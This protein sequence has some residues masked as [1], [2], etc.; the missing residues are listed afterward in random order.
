MRVGKKPG[1]RERLLTGI[2]RG[3]SK[4]SRYGYA[5]GRVMVNEAS[6][7]T[8]NQV[9]RL[10]ESD[11]DDALT[12]SVETVY[13]P[14]LEGSSVPQDIQSGLAGF[15]ADQYRFLDEICAGTH[16]AEF[17][18]LKYDFHNMKVI[19][20]W[21]Y[22][23][24]LKDGKPVIELGA[25][26]TEAL[27]EAVE[28]RQ[29]NRLPGY[30]KDVIGS[31]TS[32]LEREEADPQLL[33][34]IL[35]RAFLERR[36]A[37]AEKEGS[38]LMVDFCRAAVD[39]AN[40]NVTLRGKRLGKEREFYGEALAEG[41]RLLK[42]DLL[43]LSDEPFSV[44]A[45]RL[46]GSRYGSMLSAVLE[47]GDETVRLTTLDRASDEYILDKVR[48]FSRVSVGPERIVR[49]MLARE[50]EVLMLKI[51]FMGK[52]HSLTPEVIEARLPLS[53]IKQPAW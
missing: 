28:E 50:N 4:A 2:P 5:V 12:V 43:E 53:Y 8:W 42:K 7:V 45:D 21:H 26:A 6:F 35:D 9:Q 47:R 52:L 10:I 48:G 41:G 40:L 49:Y 51:I 34:T 44:V 31:V 22:F 18:H 33:D 17:M 39:V 23:G 37:V 25:V 20:K 30:L 38:R 36:L 1:A 46:L 27:Q 14:Y 32:R 13:G 19:L 29:A 16:V 15:L 24:E 3:F 11:Y